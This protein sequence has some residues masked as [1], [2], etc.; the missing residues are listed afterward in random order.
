[1]PKK[2]KDHDGTEVHGR[3]LRRRGFGKTETDGE[4]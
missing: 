2:D 3:K 1:M 4:A